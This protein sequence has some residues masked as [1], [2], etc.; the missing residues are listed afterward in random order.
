MKF[1]MYFKFQKHTYE[2]YYPL[3]VTCEFY[4]PLKKLYIM[5]S[6]NMNNLHKTSMYFVQNK[7]FETLFPQ[8]CELYCNI[9]MI[10]KL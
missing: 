4:Y 7:F 3:H 1:L 9:L 6:K 2:F 5:K 8:I 10:F